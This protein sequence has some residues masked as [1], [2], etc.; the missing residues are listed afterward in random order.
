MNSNQRCEL[1]RHKAVC[2]GHLPALL[3]RISE[4]IGQAMAQ[5]PPGPHAIMSAFT[6]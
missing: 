3:M 2:N 1:H 5:W 4:Y 6:Q